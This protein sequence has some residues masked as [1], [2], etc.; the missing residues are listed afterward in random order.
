VGG[1]L[2]ISINLQVLRLY[3]LGRGASHLPLRLLLLLLVELVV[4]VEGVGACSEEKEMMPA[5]A[6]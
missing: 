3:I 5:A 2:G 1:S 4:R 6:A